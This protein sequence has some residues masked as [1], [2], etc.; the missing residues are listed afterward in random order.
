[1]FFLQYFT[2]LECGH[3]FCMQ[4]WGDYLTTKI[5]EEGMGQVPAKIYLE[6]KSLINV[7]VFRKQAATFV[8]SVLNWR[9]KDV[10]TST[11]THLP[12]DILHYRLLTTI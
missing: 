2:G 4:C 7:S 5:I 12:P 9:C 10:L 11:S 8:F 3:K 6:F 1:M